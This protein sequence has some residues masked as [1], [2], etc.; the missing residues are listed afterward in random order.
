M[1]YSLSLHM[2]KSVGIES[3]GIENQTCDNK[4]CI[5]DS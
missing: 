5:S 4:T 3:V 1:K 2:I